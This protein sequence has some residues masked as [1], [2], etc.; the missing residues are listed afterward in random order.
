M[1]ATRLARWWG[2]IGPG[3]LISE[4]LVL[5][6]LLAAPRLIDQAFVANDLKPR[7]AVLVVAH[8]AVATLMLRRPMD[9]IAIFGFA[10]IAGD[11]QLAGLLVARDGSLLSPALAVAV[12]TFLN[13]LAVGGWLAPLLCGGFYLL[14]SYT[15]AVQDA[16]VATAWLPRLMFDSKLGVEPR[17]AGQVTVVLLGEPHAD[18]GPLF[19]CMLAAA[20]GFTCWIGGAGFN[21]LLVGRRRRLETTISVAL[22]LVL[23]ASLPT[24]ASAA[25]ACREI[26]RARFVEGLL[27]LG[28]HDLPAALTAF[29]RLVSEQPSCV[30]A[31]NNLA[32]ILSEMGRLQEASE[33]LREAD[34]LQP[35]YGRAR[36]NLR[37]LSALQ[38]DQPGAGFDESVVLAS[39]FP[40]LTASARPTA[41]ASATPP[42]TRLPTPTATESLSVSTFS[43]E[44]EQSTVCAIDSRAK[45]ICVYRREGAGVE[46]TCLYADPRNLE[47][48]SPWFF[49]GDQSGQR[50]WFLD[51]LGERV[52][53]ITSELADPDA[54][55]VILQP[56]GLAA[57]DA[58]ILPLQSICVLNRELSETSAL[59]NSGINALRGAVEA[60]RVAW[61]EQRVAAYDELYSDDFVPQKE[62]NR[63]TWLAR[64]SAT[65]DSDNPIEIEVVHPTFVVVDG[66][67][68]GAVTFTQRYRNRS[69]RTEAP[70]W[71][72]WRR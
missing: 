33:Q 39:L 63:A 49:F 25:T 30:E 27:A 56:A 60:W 40:P 26:G 20:V 45:R 67:I 37:R 36:E 11:A 53:S 35:G 4:A 44:A 23:S 9:L 42:A 59:L 31:R 1:W 52:A 62:P 7:L 14:G 47:G 34:R 61:S 16:P 54:K 10:L 8:V 57:L 46:S 71:M 58:L 64:R 66:A 43:F 15:A 41:A 70:K 6:A 28:H 51:A 24:A 68:S 29:Q 72:L 50:S 18:I 55:T 12:V 19:L 13:G 65:F 3:C 48:G 21:L 38:S 32:V 5:V 17:F 22:A 2:V 69:R